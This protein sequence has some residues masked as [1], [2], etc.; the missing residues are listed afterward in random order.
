[1]ANYHLTKINKQKCYYL[2][3][4]NMHFLPSNLAGSMVLVWCQSW[5]LVGIPLVSSDGS[6]KSKEKCQDGLSHPCQCAA[7]AF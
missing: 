3:D 7:M 1:M 6:S 5:V 4:S 2:V